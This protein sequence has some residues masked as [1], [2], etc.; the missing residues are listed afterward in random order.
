MTAILGCD[1]AWDKPTGQQ[2]ADAGFVFACLYVGQDTTGKNM[3]PAVVNDYT[4]HGVKVVTNFEYGAMQ[5]LNGAKQGAIDAALGHAQATACGMPHGRPIIY[6]ADWAA[7]PAQI[8]S[9]V[10][11]YL[12]AA[13][14]VTGPGTVGAYGS[15]TLIGM[16]ADYWAQAFPGEPVYLWQTVAWSNSKWASGDEITQGGE[17]RSVGGHTIDV[18]YAHV[19]DYGQW[20]DAPTTP[21]STTEGLPMEFIAAVGADPQNAGDN[22][23][24]WLWTADGTYVGVAG[25]DDLTA[26]ESLGIKTIEI[27][28]AMHQRLVAASAKAT[29]TLDAAALGAAL[30]AGLKP[31][32]KISLTGTLT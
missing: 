6:S 4:S 15:Y 17:T 32:A 31:P 1:I 28:F 19:P 16:V 2:L 21:T 27:S 25:P 12:V 3:T 24:D 8:T 9:A 23:G 5:M 11:P 30:A 10:I 20:P 7:T 22:Q 26:L 18:D 13:R 14:E 29:V